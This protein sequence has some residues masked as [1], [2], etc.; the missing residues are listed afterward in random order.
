MGY[1]L[2]LPVVTSKVR[3]H[4]ECATTFEAIYL[5]RFGWWGGHGCWWGWGARGRILNVTNNGA[6]DDWMIFGW[7]DIVW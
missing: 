5:G 4:H 3:H 6:W 1:Q 7:Y 2:L